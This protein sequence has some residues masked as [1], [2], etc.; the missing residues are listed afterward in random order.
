MGN[1]SAIVHCRC[2]M[3]ILHVNHPLF[4]YPFV[5]NIVAVSVSFL[6]HRLSHC[7]QQIV[8]NSLPV[9]FVSLTSGEGAAVVFFLAAVL[10][11]GLPSLICGTVP[12]FGR[13]KCRLSSPYT[14]V[15]PWYSQRFESIAETLLG[16]LEKAELC[17]V[18]P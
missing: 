18:S 10:N 5:S 14:F 17:Q 2:G 4:L 3:S 9:P 1:L 11:W 15:W 13:N 16:W 12:Y 8:L 6:S 7:F